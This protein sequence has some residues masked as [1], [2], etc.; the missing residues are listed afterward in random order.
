MV[1]KAQ[2]EK[3]CLSFEGVEKGSS[4]GKPSFLL[5]K[6]FFTRL[7]NEDN[8]VVLFVGSIDEREMLMEVEPAIFHVTSHYK[9]YPIVLARLDKI[10]VATLKGKLAQHWQ[11]IAPKKFVKKAEPST[12][13]KPAKAPVKKSAKRNTKRQSSP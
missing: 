2:Y 12:A 7:R 3:I 8:S 10:D 4:Y 5:A 13:K 9:D 11:R 6:K 1:S